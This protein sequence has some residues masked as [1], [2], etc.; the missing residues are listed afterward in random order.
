MSCQ[1]KRPGRTARIA[2]QE[3]AKRRP[4]LVIEMW[5]RVHDHRPGRVVCVAE[6]REAVV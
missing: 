4:V 6:Y 5:P 3:R 1:H 2:R